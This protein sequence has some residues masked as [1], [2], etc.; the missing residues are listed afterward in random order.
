[1]AAQKTTSHKPRLLKIGSDYEYQ[2][3]AKWPYPKIPFLR[4]R[5]Y[6]IAQAGFAIDQRVLVS[7]RKHRIT[8]TPLP[9]QPTI[10]E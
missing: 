3:R 9:S 10:M 8:I 2:K 7:V 1:M 5:G 6:W 4:L